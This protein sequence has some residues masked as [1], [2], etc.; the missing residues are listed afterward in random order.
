MLLENENWR[1]GSRLMAWWT[2]WTQITQNLFLGPRPQGQGIFSYIK[3][4]LDLNYASGS[5][6]VFFRENQVCDFGLMAC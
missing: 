3:M 2:I 1:M 5:N 4:W 6:E